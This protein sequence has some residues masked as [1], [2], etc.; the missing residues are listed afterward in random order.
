MEA[1][2]YIVQLVNYLYIFLLSVLRNQNKK[3]L[4][5]FN[6][7]TSYLRMAA[8]MIVLECKLRQQL[9][10]ISYYLNHGLASCS[11]KDERKAL[12]SRVEF[13]LNTAD[14]CYCNM[15]AEL[16]VLHGRAKIEYKEKLM[17]YKKELF[18]L[19]RTF[20]YLPRSLITKGTWWYSV[21]TGLWNYYQ[22]IVSVH[23]VLNTITRT[24]MT[25]LLQTANL[26][27][28]ISREIILKC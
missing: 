20:I 18:H 6:Q 23:M 2:P 21:I 24:H 5:A 22:I 3:W 12:L 11:S 25:L 1:I 27:V 17:Q 28:W 7:T 10:H 13:N 19:S 14:A 4:V 8:N 9:L 16:Q 26:S 15:E